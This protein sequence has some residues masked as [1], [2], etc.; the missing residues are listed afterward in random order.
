MIRL[1][2]MSSPAFPFSHINSNEVN[3]YQSCIFIGNM[4]AL[5]D[6]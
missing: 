5:N 1:E 3:R 6:F 4:T 2:E